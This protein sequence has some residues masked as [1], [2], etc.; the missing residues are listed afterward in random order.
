MNMNRI[1]C[2]SV[3]HINNFGHLENWKSTA[4]K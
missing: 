1:D 2:V 3:A 4:G